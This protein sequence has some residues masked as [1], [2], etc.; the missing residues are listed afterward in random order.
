MRP[1]DLLQVLQ[2]LETGQAAILAELRVLAD[3]RPRGRC[4]PEDIALLRVLLP[5]IAGARGSE[6]F[7]VNEIYADNVIRVLVA[8]L[9]AKQVGRLLWRG[10]VTVDGYAVERAGHYR[11]AT[12][13]RVVRVI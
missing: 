7:N 13:W 8:P 6:I 10:T 4:T 9:S 1:D 11:G 2:R 3:G 12:L 5:A